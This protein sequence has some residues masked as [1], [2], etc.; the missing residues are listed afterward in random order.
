MPSQAKSDVTD[1]R[2]R[3]TGHIIKM[4]KLKNKTVYK[5]QVKNADKTPW[6]SVLE[7]TKGDPQEADLTGTSLAIGRF[8]NGKGSLRRRDVAVGA[9]KANS[10]KGAVY[11]CNDCFWTEGDKTDWKSSEP[12]GNLILAGDQVGSRFG[13]SVCAVNLDG[14]GR[15]ELVVGAPLFS[16]EKVSYFF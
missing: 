3:I 15:D 14:E 4:K 13:H 11:L 8:S 16:E 1:G 6:A 9:P 7:S 10:L 5:T 2:Q 12:N